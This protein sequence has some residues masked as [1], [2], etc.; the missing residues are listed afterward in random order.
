MVEVA[1]G[2]RLDV[3]GVE[4]DVGQ[5]LVVDAEGQSCKMSIFYTKSFD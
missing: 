2:G 3:E 4:A 5:S 1:E